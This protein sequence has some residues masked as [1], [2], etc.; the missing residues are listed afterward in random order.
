MTKVPIYVCGLVSTFTFRPLVGL[1]LSS[2]WSTHQDA[3]ILQHAKYKK[4]YQ[5]RSLKRRHLV[6]SAGMSSGGF[7]RIAIW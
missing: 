6:D 4:I 2:N 1:E 3:N 5:L 7:D